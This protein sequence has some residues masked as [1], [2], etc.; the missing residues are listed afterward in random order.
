MEEDLEVNDNNLIN[1]NDN[2]IESNKKDNQNDVNVIENENVE[3]ID[4]NDSDEDIIYE[5]VQSDFNPLYYNLS[6]YF[7]SIRVQLL[8]DI[9]S[10]TT[11]SY[12]FS[13]NRGNSSRRYKQL[14]TLYRYLYSSL[15][16]K[17]NKDFLYNTYDEL[18]HKLYSINDN[19]DLGIEYTLINNLGLMI[20]PLIEM[21]CR[22]NKSNNKVEL[23]EK[24]G[25]LLTIVNDSY[26]FGYIY[27]LGYTVVITKFKKKT[28]IHG[29]F[30]IPFI[31][32][33]NNRTV[34]NYSRL[35]DDILIYFTDPNIKSYEIITE[36]NKILSKSTIDPMFDSYFNLNGKMKSI[37]FLSLI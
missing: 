24:C 22:I 18:F 26:T 19:R 3:G 12:I 20:S 15:K 13:D 7:K 8:N 4:S 6:D 35:G 16:T 32:I 34:L 30:V 36:T 29:N 27:L 28:E 25:F 33:K 37:E 11:D 23:I 1:D 2:K 10:T 17:E 14:L 31:N 5:I 9:K 21:K